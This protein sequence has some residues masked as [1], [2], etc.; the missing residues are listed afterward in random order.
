[1]AL[2]SEGEEGSGFLGHDLEIAALFI[3]NGASASGSQS[4]TELSSLILTRALRYRGGSREL[5]FDWRKVEVPALGP[6]KL[7]AGV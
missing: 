7:G 4:S 3:R 2:P 6:V 5:E 1:M